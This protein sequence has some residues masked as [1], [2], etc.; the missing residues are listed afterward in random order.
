V[1]DYSAVEVGPL[2]GGLAVHDYVQYAVANGGMTETE[3][4]CS[5]FIL[6]AMNAFAKLPVQ[7]ESDPAEFC[8]AVHTLQQLLAMRSARRDYPDFYRNREAR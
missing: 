4:E 7:H 1:K 8:T 5:F 2:D 6:M 3:A